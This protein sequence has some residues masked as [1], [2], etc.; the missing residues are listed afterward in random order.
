M[1]E[2][3]PDVAANSLRDMMHRDELAVA[4]VVKLTRGVEIVSIAKS[5]GFDAICVDLAHSTLDMA[6]AQQLCIAAL[7]AGFAPLVRV[8]WLSPEHIGQALDAGAFGVVVPQVRSAD[9][10][11]AIVRAAKYPPFGDRSVSI[12]YAQ[13]G[14]RH[15]PAEVAI[16]RL[17]EITMVV[18]MI[19]T[20]EALAHIEEI[21]AVDGVD[22]ALIGGTDLTTELGIPGQYGHPLARDA[23]DRI[24]AAFRARNKFVGAAGVTSDQAVAADL[25]KKGVRY[26]SAGTDFA[27]LSAEAARKAGQLRTMNP[28]L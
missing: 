15:V 21:A 5:A 10:A 23:Y 8:P 13:F 17:N 2:R 27:F 11:R 20:A 24:I 14:Y 3:E 1:N 18:P 19:E 7:H 9:D 6:T 4:M 12:T 25:V 22:M 28:G 16:A 26:V